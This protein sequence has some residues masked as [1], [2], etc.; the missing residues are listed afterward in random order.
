MHGVRCRADRVGLAVCRPAGRP[1]G[2]GPVGLRGH[3]AG[4]RRRPR[5]DR[6]CR[7]R[8]RR[9]P[10]PR[11]PRPARPGGRR[12]PARAGSLPARHRPGRPRRARAR[13]RPA[14]PLPA[15]PAPARVRRGARLHPHPADASAAHPTGLR[16]PGPRLHRP[17]GDAHRAARR[18][19]TG[20]RSL[21]GRPHDHAHRAH[22]AP[23]RPALL[24]PGPGRDRGLARDRTPTGLGHPARAP[25]R[26]RRAPRDQ[27]VDRRPG[28]G[29]P[30]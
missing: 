17:A 6:P 24:P 14:P 28:A 27:R 4:H 1:R 16:H 22:G 30:P 11:P 7:G 20:L 5:N 21:A 25:R 15:R 18:A 8:R 9:Q 26:L 29:R 10:G 13:P 19:P 12:R 3:P 2:P 23:R